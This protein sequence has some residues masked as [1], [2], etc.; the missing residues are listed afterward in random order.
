ME[1]H[2]KR[3][4]QELKDAGMTAYGFLKMETAK[5]PNIIH[6]DEHI[7]GVVYGRTT[8]DKIGSAMLIATDKR[9]VFLDVKPLFTTMDE[10]SYVVVS[11]IKE[12]H[13]GP[14]AGVILH[15]KVRDY[16]LRFVNK[17]CA[18][19]FVEYIEHHLEKFAEDNKLADDTLD[20]SV[21]Q[22]K[23]ETEITYI[24]NH[25][26]A[27][28]STVSQSGV[29]R[30]SVIHYVYRDGYFYFVTKD[31]SLKS[32]NIA[33]HGQVALTIHDTNSLKTAQI[34]GLAEIESDKRVVSTVIK[35]I[36]TPKHYKEGDHFPPII[37]MKKGN[38][39]VLRIV[40]TTIEFHDYSKPSW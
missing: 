11:G 25:S 8:G 36:S 22:L 20:T 18:D 37:S 23:E 24:K 26:T 28:L 39:E 29:A 17:K 9:I 6:Q 33:L 21:I 4:A 16:G 38:F 35:E 15:T 32:Q 10:V 34:S 27:I 3:V 5:L 1:N 31:E 2:K 7:G 14:F 40:P 12:S 13:A 30:G 19:R